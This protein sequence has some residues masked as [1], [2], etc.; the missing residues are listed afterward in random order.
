MIRTTAQ[1]RLWHRAKDLFPPGQVLRYLAVGVVN[2]LFGYGLFALT[3]YLLT[4]ALPSHWL[5]LT[6]VLASIISTPLNITISYFN[7]KLWVFKTRGNH[8]Q[9]WLKAFGVYGV[10][11]LPGLLALSALTRLLQYVLHSHEPFGK[12]TAGYLAGAITTGFSVILG[13]IGH[14]KVTFRQKPSTPAD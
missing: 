14:R 4:H 7:Y 8:L 13:F 5:A 9:E 11:M 3:L 6:A 2:T 12:G 1:P 10:S